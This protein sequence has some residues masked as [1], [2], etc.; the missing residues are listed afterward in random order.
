MPMQATISIVTICYNA[1]NTIARTLRSVT[2]QTY[3]HIE[4]IV[5]DGASKDSTLDKVRTLAPQ[6][7]IVSETDSGIYDAM[8]KGLSRATGDYI[9]FLNAGDA[10]PSS[11][12]V[13]DMINEATSEGSYPDVIYG[14]CLLI[15]AQDRV[16]GP[17]RLRPPLQ[18]S[19]RS[20]MD[21][22]LV[23]HQSFIAKRSICPNYDMRYRLSS[24]VDWCIRVMKRAH[25]FHRIDRPLSLYLHEGA[26]TANHRKS[27]CERFVVMRR[28]Y[29]LLP[30]L[31]KHIVFL[32]HRQR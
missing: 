24:D 18:L 8:N 28:H 32:I 29:G 10:L 15:D 22:M 25:T 1:A 12:T 2:A 4:Y 5:I 23:C 21:G 27:L 7:I 30:T 17:R 26:T 20:F 14:D 11:T 9:W 3:P 19:W 6:A 16:L 13:A 31:W